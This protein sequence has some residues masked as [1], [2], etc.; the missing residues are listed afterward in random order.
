[1]VGDGS[2]G[3]TVEVGGMELGEVVVEAIKIKGPL[4][5]HLTSS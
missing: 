4:A 1:M 5:H 2:G 3:A